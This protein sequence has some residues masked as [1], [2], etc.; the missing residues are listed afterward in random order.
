VN[1]KEGRGREDRWGV[2]ESVFPKVETDLLEG[3]TVVLTRYDERRKQ[4]DV[5]PALRSVL[6]IVTGCL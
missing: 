2:S 6:V 5:F 1:R 3:F 4:E